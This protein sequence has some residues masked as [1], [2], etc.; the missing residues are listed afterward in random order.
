VG[1]SKVVRTDTKQACSGNVL[2][3]IVEINALVERF[4]N[5]LSGALKEA[6]VTLRDPDFP[7][8]Q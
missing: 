2:W 4:V 1:E 5:N 6:T 8:T 3:I 7:G